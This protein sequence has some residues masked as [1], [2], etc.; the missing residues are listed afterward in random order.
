MNAKRERGEGKREKEKETAQV[1]IELVGKGVG[2]DLGGLGE[3]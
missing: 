2:G 3:W 1:H